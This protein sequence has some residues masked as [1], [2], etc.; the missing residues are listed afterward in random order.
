AR[1]KLRS[2]KTYLQTCRSEL[3]KEL[4]R[5]LNGHEHLYQHVH[6]Y[7]IEDL[8][9]VPSGSLLKTLNKSITFA[10]DHVRSCPLCSQ[11]GF[12]CEICRADKIIYPFEVDN[13][14]RCPSCKALYH[15]SCKT[16]QV[17]CP[18]CLR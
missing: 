6:Q 16:P 10:V 15:A 5:L 14:V 11:K 3:L 12:Y 1:T 13:T 2:L 9:S 4:H 17:S 7:S 8:V 18:K